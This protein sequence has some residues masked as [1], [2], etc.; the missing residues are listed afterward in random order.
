MSAA[1]PKKS[2]S[3]N[4]KWLRTYPWLVQNEK[5]T[6]M[7]CNHCVSTKKC[8]PFASENGCL[9][10]QNSTLVRHQESKD[11]SDAVK[12]L[13]L[14]NNFRKCITSATRTDSR[15]KNYVTQLRTVYVMCKN[16]ISADNFTE[17]MNLQELNG[18]ENVGNYYR[19]LRLYPKWNVFCQTLKKKSH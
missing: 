2:R 13:Q 19:S 10:F 1:P 18:C 5:T 6:G 12:Q 9:N 16:N 15:F 4:E 14:R 7:K 8:N 11:H 17:L 3:F